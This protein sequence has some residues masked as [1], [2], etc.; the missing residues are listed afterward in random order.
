MKKNRSRDKK[1]VA[2]SA[3]AYSTKNSLS[4]SSTSISSTTPIQ[5]NSCC[6]ENDISPRVIVVLLIIVVV[7]SLV[8]IG[9]FM[10]SSSQEPIEASLPQSSTMVTNGKITLEV[11]P[12]PETS[13]P[14]ANKENTGGTNS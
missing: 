12:Q 2:K 8:S 9:L 7:T 11:L 14:E 10:Y 13:P 5:R 4:K 6:Q 3:S 1:R